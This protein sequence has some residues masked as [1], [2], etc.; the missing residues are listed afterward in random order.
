MN[1][2]LALLLV[3]S[4]AHALDCLNQQG[5]P[6]DWWVIFKMPKESTTAGSNFYYSDPSTTL[7]YGSSTIDSP[8]SPFLRTVAQHSLF[9]IAW[10]DQ[11]SDG[12]YIANHAHSKGVIQAD[13]S[14][15]FV[16]NHS[17]PKFPYISDG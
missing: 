12:T 1:P 4:V 3:L 6:V 16:I 9:T 7:Q 17:L 11:K 10:N 13:S 5:Q 15:G 8:Q 14:S 2:T